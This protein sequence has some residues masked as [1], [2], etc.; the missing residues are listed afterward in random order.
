MW[1]SP[2]H[3]SFVKLNGLYKNYR[4]VWPWLSWFSRVSFRGLTLRHFYT[5]CIIHDVWSATWTCMLHRQAKWSTYLHLLAW[6]VLD[7]TIKGFNSK[8]DDTY[9]PS[10]IQLLTHSSYIEVICLHT[11]IDLTVMSIVLSAAKMTWAAG[12]GQLHTFTGIWIED[13]STES[14]VVCYPTTDYSESHLAIPLHT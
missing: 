3:L 1:S 12:P 8:E 10:W 14:S 7:N 13:R 11:F 4:D 2:G 6:S 9:P 5:E